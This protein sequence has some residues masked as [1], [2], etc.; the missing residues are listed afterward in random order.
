MLIEAEKLGEIKAILHG[1]SDAQLLKMQQAAVEA[2]RVLSFG[3][4]EGRCDAFGLMLAE[5]ETRLGKR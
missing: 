1:I 5:L 4:A 2:Y 3:E